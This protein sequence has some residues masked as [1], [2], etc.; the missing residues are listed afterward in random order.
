MNIIIDIHMNIHM[1]IHKNINLN[2]D[3]YGL[4]NED[5]NKLDKQAGAELCQAQGMLRLA[6]LWL[7]P[8]FNLID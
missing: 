3:S 4:L 5:F 1:I 7:V 8:C 2:K 6:G